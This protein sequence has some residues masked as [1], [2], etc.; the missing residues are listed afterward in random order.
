MGD[1]EAGREGGREERTRR[2]G[3]D[4]GDSN[5]RAHELLEKSAR[6]GAEG[7]LK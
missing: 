1:R 4:L 7:V 5:R 6:E 3:L 2:T